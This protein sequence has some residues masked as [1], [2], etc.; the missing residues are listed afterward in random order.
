[1][2]EMS[3]IEWFETSDVLHQHTLSFHNMPVYIF[4]LN[5]K[6]VYNFEFEMG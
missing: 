4:H 2:T 5:Y 6:N 1:M 3:V